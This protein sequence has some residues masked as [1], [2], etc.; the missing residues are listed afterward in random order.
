MQT[1]TK[2]AEQRYSLMIIDKEVL[3]KMYMPG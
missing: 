3:G 1:K 2:E